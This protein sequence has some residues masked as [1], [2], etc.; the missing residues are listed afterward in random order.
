MA[1]ETKLLAEEKDQ[2]GGESDAKQRVSEG[3]DDNDDDDGSPDDE[4]VEIEEEEANNQNTDMPSDS[5]ASVEE[6]E[7]AVG[8]TETDVAVRER[9]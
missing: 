2:K 1:E 9:S 6:A 7:V 4:V 8:E 5:I 3:M